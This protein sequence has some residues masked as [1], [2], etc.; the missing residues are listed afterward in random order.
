MLKSLGRGVRTFIRA[1]DTA[2]AIRHGATLPHYD[3]VVEPV[4]VVP[5][6]PTEWGDVPRHAA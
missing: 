2:N 5:I 3:D 4:V 1:L 6:D